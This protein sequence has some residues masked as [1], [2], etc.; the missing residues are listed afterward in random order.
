MLANSGAKWDG[1]DVDNKKWNEIKLVSMNPPVSVVLNITYADSVYCI[2]NK[3]VKLELTSEHR[4][5]HVNV[6]RLCL[7][8]FVGDT[9]D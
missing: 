7:H 9:Y 4:R 1:D 2:P 3:C 8:V 5:C 6:I